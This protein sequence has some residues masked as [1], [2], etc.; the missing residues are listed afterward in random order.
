MAK[1]AGI[2]F[3]AISA[4]KYRRIPHASIIKKL[5]DTRSLALNIRDIGRTIRGVT[6]SL[7]LLK[8][9]KPDVVFC[10][11]GFVALPV[12]LAAK[13]LSLPLVIHESD[14]LPGLGTSILSTR[15]DFIAVG[16]P[17]ELYT[18]LPASKLIYT[19]NPVRKEI[20]NPAISKESAI[21]QFFGELSDKPIVLVLGGSQGATAINNAILESAS[22]IEKSFRVILITG[23]LDYQ[24]VV[25]RFQ[26]MGIKE[27]IMVKP[28]LDAAG[29][30]AAYKAADV[31]VS[32]AGAN[33]IA[34]LAATGKSVILIPNRLMASHQLTN[35]QRLHSAGAVELLN[36][37]ELSAKT[38]VDKLNQIAGS[39]ELQ[40]ALSSKLSQVYVEDSASRLVDLFERAGRRQDS[41]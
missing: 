35:A 16:F 29:M 39:K 17:V 13:A 21:K 18:K 28:F 34:E 41:R 25:D 3:A 36:E 37:E 11:G 8:R 4:G 33:T 22:E 7:R 23:N 24:R 40:L 38:I 15:A 12:G 9:F 27:A 26:A 31:V 10:K 1:A 14:I 32:R 6:A 19:G 20:V 30:A 2:D 5:T